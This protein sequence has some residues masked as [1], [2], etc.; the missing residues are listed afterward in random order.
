MGSCMLFN[1]DKRLH[2]ILH[3]ATK[4]F[5]NVDIVFCGDFYQARPI[6]DAYIF[7]HPKLHGQ[8]IPY[9]FWKYNVKCSKYSKSCDKMTKP[10]YLS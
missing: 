7:E 8:K 6:F 5:G 3:M 1:M 4:T 9:M 2:E 10:S